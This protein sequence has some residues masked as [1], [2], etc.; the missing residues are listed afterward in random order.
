MAPFR[1]V[2]AAALV[3]ST[4]GLAAL[5]AKMQQPQVGRGGRGGPPPA[6]VEARLGSDDAVAA[7][8]EQLKQLV[9]MLQVK[10]GDQNFN[11]AGIIFGRG[12]D[13][14]YI[15]TAKHVVRQALNTAESVRVRF[16]WLPGESKEGRVLDDSD[17]SLDIAV[18]AVSG[19]ASLSLPNLAWNALVS[20]GSV[21]PGAE[22]VP[23]GFPDGRQWFTPQLRSRVQEVTGQFVEFQGELHAGNSG[24][25]LVT[26][27]WGIV[28]IVSQIRPPTNQSSRIDRA[29]E[30]LK[31]WG[32][33]VML[34]ELPAG[35]SATSAPS[36]Q[37]RGRGELLPPINDRTRWRQM[38]FPAPNGGDV[39]ITT[40]DG[41][42][43]CASYNGGGCLWGVNADQ[44][45]YTRLVPLVC[46]EAHRARWGVTGY[47][48]PKHWCSLARQ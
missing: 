22:V 5:E 25:A 37:G 38:A 33:P 24:G 40:I 3:V 14:L 32:Y 48:D 16:R 15:V 4:C 9:V 13:Q 27:D 43:A 21:K 12:G 45:D 42:P 6:S 10:L 28:S 44:V 7:R 23:I 11:G 8:E 18:L 46:G 31:E 17:E 20:P 29:I 26:N 41:N 2:A 36:A 47:D 39:L 30:K 1:F 34:T 19:V 35:S